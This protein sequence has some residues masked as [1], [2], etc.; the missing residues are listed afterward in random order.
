VASRQAVN[1]RLKL[2]VDRGLLVASVVT[3]PTGSGPHAYGLGARARDLLKMPGP[4]R[5]RAIGPLWH[6]LEIA[7]FRVSLELALKSARGAIIE[8]QGEPTLRRLLVG[9]RGLPIP[10]ASVHWALRGT[11]GTFL[12]EWDRGSETLAILTA[13][14][15][16]Y[17]RWWRE[18][19]QSDVLPGL[20]LRPRLAIVVADAG[21]A[22]RLVRWLRERRTSLL[23]G[24]VLVG[25]RREA[26][27]DP[28][29]A[30]WWRSD[31]DRLGGLMR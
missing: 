28:L 24:T 5:Q 29:G 3:T 9:R 10:D 31:I 14:L 7:D 19:G 1:A 4:A 17:R 15:A 25:V 16:R 6:Q 30:R 2:L 26:T 18:R 12:L 21:R 8:W 13:K 11:E 23:Q 20:G 27:R 22:T